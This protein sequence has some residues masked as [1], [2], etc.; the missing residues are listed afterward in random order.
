DWIVMPL[1]V[2]L[3]VIF[4]IGLPVA[5]YQEAVADKFELRKDQ[6]TCSAQHTE[7]MPMAKGWLISVMVCDTWQ[8]D[9]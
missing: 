6:W 4:V 3:M 1:L 8:R 2:L 7:F 9:R 5:I